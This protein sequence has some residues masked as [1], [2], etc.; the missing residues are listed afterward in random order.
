MS[1]F[2]FPFLGDTF[3]CV[4]LEMIR[5]PN[6][7]L[8]AL[9]VGGQTTDFSIF[10]SISIYYQPPIYTE[11]AVT[12]HASRSNLRFWCTILYNFHLLQTITNLPN[13]RFFGEM[14]NPQ[15]IRR[16]LQLEMGE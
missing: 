4:C 5:I 3:A 11:I 13:L 1:G 6:C 15:I 2:L 9:I 16:H 8:P 10:P 7:T 12:S 14:S